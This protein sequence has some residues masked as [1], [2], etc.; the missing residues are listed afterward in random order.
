M[1]RQGTCDQ[2]TP[3]TWGSMGPS[4]AALLGEH[5][6]S[7][8]P[9]CHRPRPQRACDNRA[10][11]LNFNLIAG[12]APARNAAL[13]PSGKYSPPR[14]CCRA[15]WRKHWASDPLPIRAAVGR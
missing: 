9:G 1:R 15:R 13:T 11:L 14:R 5:M 7:E 6:N 4:G 3:E 12:G 10:T 2:S 8:R